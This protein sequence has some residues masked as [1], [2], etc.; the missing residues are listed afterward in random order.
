MS[1]RMIV[2]A[3]LACSCIA[4]AQS[5]E[6]GPTTQSSATPITLRIEN[7]SVSSAFEQFG[8]A[9]GVEV[10]SNSPNMWNHLPAREI[11]YSCDRADYWN[12]LSAL[13]AQARVLP[14]ASANGQLKLLPDGI[15]WNAQPYVIAGPF[16]I[17]AAGVQGDRTLTFGRVPRLSTHCYLTLQ[18]YSEPHVQAA[19]VSDVSIQS[20][21]GSDGGAIARA[22]TGPP[23]APAF[24]RGIAW[25]P[26]AIAPKRDVR[27]ISRLDAKVGIVVV[28]ASDL[29]KIPRIA[30]GAGFKRKVGTTSLIFTTHPAEGGCDI[31]TAV[32]C[33]SHDAAFRKRVG[34]ALRQV[35]PRLT[36][37]QGHAFRI[38]GGGSGSAASGEVSVH[39]SFRRMGG[40][41]QPAGDP[42]TLT[43]QIPT[44]FTELSE[45][46]H[47]EGLDLP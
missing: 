13:C 8:R 37:S 23:I 38:M 22:P 20:L 47:F 21:Q 42:D 6:P 24:N 30:Q 39:W 29:I 18:I 11:S 41:G 5:P 10:S 7:Q 31:E 27:Q 9:A 45:S 40:P 33:E 1:W 14:T 44:A 19:Y 34:M 43:W 35:E 15:G 46:I 4:L 16:R 2:I 36:D 28:T 3:L 32:R 25:V 26:I 17:A 12:A